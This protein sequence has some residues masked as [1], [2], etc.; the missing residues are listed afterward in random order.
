MSR[1]ILPFT[2]AN[3]KRVASLFRQALRTA[4]DSSLKFDAYRAETIKIRAQFEANKHISDPTELES[5]IAATR[6]K[7]AEYA[8][9]DPYFP[10]CRPG[11]TK[12]QRNIPVARE[13]LVPGDW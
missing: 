13:P 11:G 5:V 9:P 2:E 3:S 4:F 7:L 8:H 1:A 12:Y 6:A 10:P